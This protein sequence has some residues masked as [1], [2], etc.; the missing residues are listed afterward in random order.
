[1]VRCGIENGQ[2]VISL[3]G[4]IDSLNAREAEQEIRAAIAENPGVPFLLDA[5][6]LTYISSAGLR[7][8]L[9]VKKETE[10]DVTIRNVSQEV[11]ETFEVTGFN[12]LFSVKKKLRE[13][14]VE[15][16]PVIGKGA[17]GTVYL[18]DRDTV[19]KV[20]GIPD[21]LAMIEN[22]Q[23]RSKQAFLRGIPTAIS[24]D[25]VRV[26]DKYGSV[27]EMVN[28]D[29]CNRLIVTNP[30]RT[31]E[32]LRIYTDF[33]IT[34]HGVKMPRGELPDARETYAGYVRALS[35]LPEGMAE[36][37]LG[38]IADMPEDLHAVHGDVQM[39]NVMLSDREPLLIDMET[40]CVGDPVFEFAGLF[41][42][43]IA[44]NDAEP[45][46][47]M[48]FFGFDAAACENIYRRVL[49]LYLGDP[50]ENTLRQAED[51]IEIL[52]YIRF[53]YLIC[54]MKH[55]KEELTAVRISRSAER[56][57]KLLGRVTKL[58]LDL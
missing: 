16:C 54:V 12:T 48:E 42:A 40:L 6:E 33:L 38:L 29:N 15:G 13:I 25:V 10:G 47:S 5:S 23:K 37:I 41:V 32:I 18:L 8:L 19:V 53:L 58:I 20:Y 49:R 7:A 9:T 31:G 56:L 36:R 57:E 22:E 3:S 50:D 45:G 1:M 43:Y 35:V 21:C 55:G 4:K 34:V 30:E 44:Y 2:L 24:Y 17:V 51:R 39:K 52:G 28:A 26:G 27:F 11:W 46:N 14:S